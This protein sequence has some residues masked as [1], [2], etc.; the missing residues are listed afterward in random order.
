[1]AG[2]SG[3]KGLLRGFRQIPV[4]FAN[5]GACD[6]D[7]ANLVGFCR[8]ESSR[9]DDRNLCV[10]PGTTAADDRAGVGLGIGGDDRLVFLKG[11]F[12][13]VEDF[14]RF[15]FDAACDQ[16]GGFCHAVAGV[17]SF[18]TETLG[19]E[20]GGKAIEG[21]GA[22]G[23]GSGEG[24][25]PGTEVESLALLWGGLAAEEV[26]GEIGCA[27]GGGFVVGDGLQPADGLLDECQ[28]GHEDAGDAEVE[29]LEDVAH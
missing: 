16:Q 2:E 3:L 21:L 25:C 10:Q 14:G 20:G 22:D 28:G 12:V 24:E 8:G 18:G 17:E 7:F 27:A 19:L 5:A 26:V 29:G 9:I 11:G 1:M 6:P 4:A 15:G 13:E 23:F